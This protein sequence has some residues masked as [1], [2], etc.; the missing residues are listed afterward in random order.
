MAERLDPKAEEK[1]RKACKDMHVLQFRRNGRAIQVV[2]NR[3][4]VAGKV[5]RF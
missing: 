1:V 2:H 5:V 4:G 3:M